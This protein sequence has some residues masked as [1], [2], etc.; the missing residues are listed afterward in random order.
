MFIIIIKLVMIKYKI[1]KFIGLVMIG[2]SLIDTE[3]Q[4]Q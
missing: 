2:A 3:T 1:T 4:S